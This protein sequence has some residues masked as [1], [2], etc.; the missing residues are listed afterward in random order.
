[1]LGIALSLLACST[2]RMYIKKYWHMIYHSI[3]NISEANFI[4]SD[5]EVNAVSL[6]GNALLK[7]S[8]TDG[9]KEFLHLMLKF[10]SANKNFNS[11]YIDD[12][13]FISEN[14]DLLRK[15]ITTTENS[16]L[17][18][19]AFFPTLRLVNISQGL[20]VLDFFAK[21]NGYYIGTKNQMD[22]TL[23]FLSF[24]FASTIWER[25]IILEN[26]ETDW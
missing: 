5:N 17:H 18:L 7:R 11:S 8:L 4:H 2:H 6:I 10:G 12:S 24:Y 20:Y 14:N 23:G 1:M 22:M 15:F 19:R 25:N 13:V 16:P 3:A 21:S 9:E 26:Q